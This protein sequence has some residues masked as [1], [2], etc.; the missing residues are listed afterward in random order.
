MKNQ[1]VS[2]GKEVRDKMKEDSFICTANISEFCKKQSA[3]EKFKQVGFDLKLLDRT[4][5]L[6]VEEQKDVLSNT[7]ETSKASDQIETSMNVFETPADKWIKLAEYYSNKGYSC[8]R[9]T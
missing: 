5:W 7:K 1:V 6:N 2:L 4:D 9:R 8:K 3:W